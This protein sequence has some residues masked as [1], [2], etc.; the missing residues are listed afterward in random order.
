MVHASL[1]YSQGR[2]IIKPC[3]CLQR[4]RDPM[5]FPCLSPVL[6]NI[7]GLL[8]QNRQ[9]AMSLKFDGKYCEWLVRVPSSH[10]HVRLGMCRAYM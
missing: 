4:F 3:R 8:K 5:P 6:A 10:H 1:K 7:A 9:G 2:M